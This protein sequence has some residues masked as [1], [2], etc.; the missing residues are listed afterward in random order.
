M[1]P[2]WSATE[3]CEALECAEREGVDLLVVGGGITGAGVLRDAASRGLRALLV[4]RRDFAAGTSSRSSKMIHGGLRYLGEGNLRLIREACRERDL[5]LAHNRH[6][7]RPLPFVFPA[8]AGS[9]FPL[10]QV[11]AAMLAYSMLAN[12]RPSARTRM[13]GSQEILRRVPGLRD[14][15][16]RGAGFYT[17]AQVDDVRLV[18]ESL[19][20]AR[21]LGGEAVNHAE[22]YELTRGRDGRLSG[23]RVRDNLTRRSYVLNAGVVVN[24]AGPAV[25]R[26]RGLDRPVERP[27]LRPAKG[28]HLV[29]PRARLPVE[30]A[31]LIEASDGRYVFVSPWEE[32]LLV[33]TTDDFSDEI[34]GP[35]VRIEEVHYLLSA[36][37]AAFPR[38]CLT[39]NDLR[40][41]FAGVRPLAASPSEERPPSSVSRE[42]RIYRDPSGLI[43]VAGGKLTTYRAMGE[44]IVDLALEE[45]PAA[46][47]GGLGPSRTAELP[48]RDDG[49]DPIELE[50]ALAERF[51]VAGWRAEYLVRTYGADALT[52]FEEASAELHEPVGASRYSYAEIPWAFRSECPAS[53]CDLLE[54]RLRMVIFAEGQ[55]LL[56]LDRIAEVAAAAA[57]WDRARA[58]AEAD[59]YREAVGSSYQIVSNA[60]DGARKATR[61]SAA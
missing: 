29:I 7:V 4:E 55:G 5:L 17:D 13:L 59:A 41:V 56:Q 42:D 10:W 9:K 21:R 16:L 54:R 43:S 46:R 36:V 11:R 15:G 47:R 49:F 27:E 33:G 37:N 57:G 22:V 53:L 19:K 48:L 12:F 18:L 34:D 40:S 25:E 20:S 58:R 44:R 32:V 61:R 28:I 60:C 26:V 2:R 51:A 45:L 30:C 52:L 3:R 50:S 38:V 14:A 1:T 23:A 8:Y 39:T 6:L 24:A 35:A 31:V